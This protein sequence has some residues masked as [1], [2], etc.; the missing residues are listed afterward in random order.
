MKVICIGRNYADHAKEMNAEVPSVPVFFMKPDSSI[1]RDGSPFFYPEFTKDLHFECEIVVKI[2]KLGKNISEKFAHTYYDE[3]GLGIDFTAR[4]LQGEAKSKGLPW[5]IGKAFDNSAFISKK[6]INKADLDLENISFS[7]TQN[8]TT[9]QNGSTSDLIFS[10]DKVIAYISQFVTLKI[11][12]L[13]YT[14]TPAG[15]GPIQIGDKLEGFIGEKKMYS[16]NIK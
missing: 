4:D 3:I 11:G 7:L 15:V 9:V 1:L 8:G 5:E 12:D 6:W 14:G 16:L 10:F 13:I 2:N